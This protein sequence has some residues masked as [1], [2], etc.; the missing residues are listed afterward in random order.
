MSDLIGVLLFF[1][2]FLLTE[3]VLEINSSFK[4]DEHFQPHHDVVD[5]THVFIICLLHLFF[6]RSFGAMLRL[7]IT[8]ASDDATTLRDASPASINI[9]HIY[10]PLERENDFRMLRQTALNAVYGCTA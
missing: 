5:N 10:V 3:N 2:F 4:K 9:I 8:R 6:L 7:V 1:L